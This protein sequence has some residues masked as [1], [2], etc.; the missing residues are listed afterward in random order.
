M[1]QPEPV[2]YETVSATWNEDATEEDMIKGY[3]ALIN[4][5]QAWRMEGSVGR[6]A[7]S[8]IEAGV[9]ALGENDYRDYYGNHLPSRYQVK[10]GT[11]G[12]VKYVHDHGNEVMD[13]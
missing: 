13:S 9:C 4:S 8:L 6:M 7:M 12:S 11:Q 10:E 2:D 5:G 3:Q 1:R